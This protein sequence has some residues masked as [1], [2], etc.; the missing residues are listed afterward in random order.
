MS[1]Q[2]AR[3]E[4]EFRLSAIEY[5][6]SKLWA[7]TLKASTPLSDRQRGE[8]LDQLAEGAKTQKFPGLDPSMHDLASDEYARSVKRLTDAIKSTAE[9]L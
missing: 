8:A 4:L 6:L 9:A 3:I 2:Q 7:A 1:D 5:M